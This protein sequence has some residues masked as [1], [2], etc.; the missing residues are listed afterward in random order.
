MIYLKASVGLRVAHSER[1]KCQD[2]VGALL[3]CHL[4]AYR[5]T[6]EYLSIHFSMTRKDNHAL[7]FMARE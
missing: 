6:R 3:C 7:V 1:E 5:N 2:N 4:L